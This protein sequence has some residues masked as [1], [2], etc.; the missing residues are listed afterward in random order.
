MPSQEDARG[1][2]GGDQTHLCCSSSST[3][4]RRLLYGEEQVTREFLVAGNKQESKHLKCI[5][6]AL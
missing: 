1:S 2:G 4:F 6:S 5:Q 3:D